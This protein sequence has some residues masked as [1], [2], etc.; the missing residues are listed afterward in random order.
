MKLSEAEL[1]TLMLFYSS[2]YTNV[3][4]AKI[5]GVTNQYALEQKVSVD[6]K[7][8]FESEEEFNKTLNFAQKIGFA[9]IHI[10]PFSERQGTV[11]ARMEGKLTNDIKNQRVHILDEIAQNT[12][13]QFLD[14]HI[15]K[16]VSVLFE[17]EKNG[18]LHGYTPNYVEVIAKGSITLCNQIAKVKILSSNEESVNG[19]II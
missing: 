14:S 8:I 5:L 7:T 19:E 17:T 3:E 6:K 1:E 9:K 13:K 10:F 12:R 18:F 4:I 2:L 15:G 16:E 11:A